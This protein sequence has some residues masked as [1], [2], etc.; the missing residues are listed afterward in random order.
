MRHKAVSSGI[1]EFIQSAVIFIDPPQNNPLDLV[2]K[3][4]SNHPTVYCGTHTPQGYENLEAK[5]V[6]DLELPIPTIPAKV[7]FSQ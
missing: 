2:R 7:D 1:Y 4:V 6:I 5:R 3:F